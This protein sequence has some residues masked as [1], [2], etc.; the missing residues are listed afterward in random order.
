[1]ASR[2]ASSKD[3][4]VF[5]NGAYSVGGTASAC[6]RRAARPQQLVMSRYL[7][8]RYG[9]RAL[10]E[11]RIGI[12]LIGCWPRAARLARVQPPRMRDRLFAAPRNE[13]LPRGMAGVSVTCNVRPAPGTMITAFASSVTRGVQSPHVPEHQ[14]DQLV[15]RRFGLRVTILCRRAPALKSHAP[16]GAPILREMVEPQEPAIRAGF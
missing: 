2:D 7:R 5:W 15:I 9:Q 6:N 14:L 13:L 11:R 3:G 16:S 10:R 12:Q 4:T 1:M 8:R